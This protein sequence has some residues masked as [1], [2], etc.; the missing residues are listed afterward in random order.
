LNIEGVA[1]V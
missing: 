1:V